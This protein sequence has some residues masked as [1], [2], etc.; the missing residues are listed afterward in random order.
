MPRTP[1]LDFAGARHHVMNRAID[2][3][4]I[5]HTD[6]DCALFIDTLAQLPTRYGVRIHGYALMPNHFHLM[7]ESTGGNLADAMRHLGSGFTLAYNRARAQ[8][9][10]LFRGRYRNQLVE[11][12][13]YWMNLL[14]YL[15]LNPVRAGLARVAEDCEWTSHNAYV[16]GHR[17]PPWLTCD[18]LVE[19]YGSRA[20]YAAHLEDLRFHRSEFPASFEPAAFWRAPS[21]ALVPRKAAPV[22]RTLEQALGEVAAAL[23]VPIAA[24]DGTTSGRSRPARWLAAWWVMRSTS[25]RRRDVAERFG[26]SVQRVGQWLNQA[27]RE[28]A[29]SS[30]LREAK[31][32][33]EP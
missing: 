19:L 33:L 25:L 29:T 17:T 23:G 14:A 30:A 16:G 9:G 7:V 10:P 15:H 18:E 28:T 20:N 3:R 4:P 2:R 24:F 6:A 22:G 12:D 8:D 21:T 13:E 31:A 26:V 32:I 27:S 1:R 11:S 5:L